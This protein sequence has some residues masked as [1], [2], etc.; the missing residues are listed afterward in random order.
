MPHTYFS[1]TDTAPE[2]GSIGIQVTFVDEDDVAL[3]PTAITWT[4]TN[5]PPR[6]EAPTVVNGRED[7]S[8]SVPASVITVVLS[9]NDLSFLDSAGEDEAVLVERVFTVE[10]VYTSDLGSGLPGKAQ[11]IFALERLFVYED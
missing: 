6:G 5:R 4:L 2:K 8:V 1:S 3:I 7:E 10:Y 9:G 11:Y